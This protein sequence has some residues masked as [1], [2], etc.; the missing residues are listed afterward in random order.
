MGHAM[1]C[2]ESARVPA[3]ILVAEDAEMNRALYRRLLDRCG[4]NVIETRDGAE[5]LEAVAREAPDLVLLDLRMPMIDGI[6]VLRQIRRDYDQVQLPVIVVTGDTD[7][8]TA[9]DCLSKGANDYVTKP[10]VWSVLRSRLET[11][12]R[13][14]SARQELTARFPTLGASE[15]AAAG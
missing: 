3:T 13:V 11:H 5:T 7:V 14:R 2:A 10:I 6:E 8:E 1:S 9:A 15:E 12:L 4:Y